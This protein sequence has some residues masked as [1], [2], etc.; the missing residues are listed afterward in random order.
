VSVA[1][2]ATE[3]RGT[4]A[5][6]SFSWEFDLGFSSAFDCS[7]D[8]GS[9]QIAVIVEGSSGG[10]KEFGNP[11]KA[12]LDDIY[13]F[14]IGISSGAPV[15]Q[16]DI[17]GMEIMNAQGEPLCENCETIDA[18]AV[19]ISDYSPD[20]FIVHLILHNSV[21][22][23]QLS[24]NIDFTFEITMSAERRRRLKVQENQMVSETVTLHLEPADYPI[25]LTPPPTAKGRGFKPTLKPVEAVKE[26][27]S[28]D[29][30]SVAD[31]VEGGSNGSTI[32]Y[33]A[34]AGVFLLGLALIG[35]YYMRAK[36][37]N[38][39]TIGFEGEPGAKDTE[40]SVSRGGEELL[41]IS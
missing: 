29:F 18:L 5:D 1:Y 38:Q 19:G 9:F 30:T 33:V 24:T 7:E 26:A 6:V 34:I 4:E 22:G 14:R 8:L 40:M 27:A 15:T 36:G 35:G 11:G 39:D 23:G 2:D 25:N 21:F 20:N 37:A 13:Y 28:R 3:P 12:Y 41:E 10:N 16:V 31:N 32:I 17:V